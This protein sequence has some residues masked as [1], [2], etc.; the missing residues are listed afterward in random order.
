MCLDRDFRSLFPQ[1][2]SLST[3][4]QQGGRTIYPSR[5]ELNRSRARGCSVGHLKVDP[6]NSGAAGPPDLVDHRRGFTIDKDIDRRVDFLQV[7]RGEWLSWVDPGQSR[8]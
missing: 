5:A 6:V 4:L 8:T 3:H 7:R 2:V 1:G